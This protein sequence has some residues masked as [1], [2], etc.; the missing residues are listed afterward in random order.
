MSRHPLSAALLLDHPAFPLPKVHRGGLMPDVEGTVSIRSLSLTERRRCAAQLLSACSLAAEFD[1]WPGRKAL[2]RSRAYRRPGGAQAVVM[3]F[4]LPLT[5][6]MKRLRAFDSGFDRIRDA[7]VDAIACATGIAVDDLQPEG[8]AG[9]FLEPNLRRSLDV[10]GAPLDTMTG[11]NLWAFHWHLPPMPNDGEVVFWKVPLVGMAR[12]IAGAAWVDLV[13]QAGAAIQVDDGQ[14][15]ADSE[16]GIPLVLC[17]RL[18]CDALTQAERWARSNTTKSFVVGIFPAGWDPPSLPCQ[19]AGVPLSTHLAIAGVSLDRARREVDAREGTFDPRN[20]ADRD[21]LTNAARQSY[22]TPPRSPV[23]VAGMAADPIHRVLSLRREGLPPKLVQT[24]SGAGLADLAAR[25]SEGTVVADGDRCRLPAPGLLQRDPLHSKVAMGFAEDDPRRLL[26]EALGGASKRPL[27]QWARLELDCLENRK[28]REV[29]RQVEPG[30]LGD[31]ITVLLA[32]ACLAVLDIAGGR[33]ACNALPQEQAVPW[34]LWIDVVDHPDGWRLPSIDFFDL[35]ERAPRAA[36]EAAVYE[37][38]Q[39]KK[40]NKSSSFD[41]FAVLEQAMCGLVGAVHTWYGIERV[42]L[43]EEELLF[44]Q[45]WRDSSAGANAALARFV[46]HKQ[47]IRLSNLERFPEARRILIGLADKEP[48]PGRLAR[49]FVDLANTAAEQPEDEAAHSVRALR[50][51]EVA[52]FRFAKQAMLFNLAMM[53]VEQ[54]HLARAEQRLMEGRTDGDPQ[55]AIGEGMLALGQGDRRRFNDITRELAS[56]VG[57]A[58]LHR[59][60]ELFR[61]IDALLSRRFEPARRYLIE[62]GEDG[63]PW[64]A[65]LS[66]IEGCGGMEMPARDPWKLADVGQ[67]IAEYRRAGLPVDV[68]S[69]HIPDPPMALAL[70]VADRVLASPDWLTDAT[71]SA[72][73][74]SLHKYG[75]H[76]W[77]GDFD[78]D[79]QGNL[80]PLLRAVKRVADTGSFEGLAQDGTEPILRALG[81]TGLEIRADLCEEPVIRMGHGEPNEVVRHGSLTLAALGCRPSSRDSWGLLTSVF[82]LIAPNRLISPDSDIE[83]QLGIIGESH[84][85]AVLREDI[86]RAAPSQLGVLLSGETGVGKELAARAIHDC[87]GRVGPFK[88]VNVAAVPDNLF[89]A[90]MF[91]AVKGAFTGATHDRAGFAEAADG[92]TLF[93]DEIGDLALPLQVKLLRF[94][95]SGEVRR[96]GSNRCRYVDVRVIAASNRDLGAMVTAGTFREDLWFRLANVSISVP[97]LRQRGEDILLLRDFLADNVVQ[98]AGLRQARWSN[99]AEGLLR[100]HAWPGNVRELRQV[101]GEALLRAGGDLITA[102]HLPESVAGVGESRPR[103]RRWDSAHREL[104]VELIRNALERSGGNRAAAARELGISRQTLLYHIRILSLS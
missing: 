56:G 82:S 50:L 95:D 14:I 101:V 99:E 83:G 84:P 25:I 75:M 86:R 39:R 37:A 90:E 6:L 85:I 4:P 65:L 48:E 62:G 94:L 44:D 21:A 61:G 41:P 67:V 69:H 88:P 8:G 89:E 49:V 98:E 43:F 72:V 13:R 100:Q 23:R 73:V 35:V 77:A 7:A 51:F 46:D 3:G 40:G 47:A 93:L 103:V 5:H 15:P 80:G 53:D 11:R 102:A 22:A 87:S 45:V 92:G 63:E 71:R 91:G 2:E 70:A 20:L 38:R 29:L 27:E 10:L 96:V 1:L 54:L 26:H 58:R 36:A 30:E 104:R 64:L 76:G 24:L 81:V 28:V 18:G 12:R 97:P 52:G 31:S 34:R 19:R 32:E 33:E 55:W 17:G 68:S 42:S 74:T 60:C 66:E 9:F 78:R 57:E 59:W 79:V 16:P